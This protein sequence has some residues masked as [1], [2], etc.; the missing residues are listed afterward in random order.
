[1]DVSRTSVEIA[2]DLISLT[3]SLAPL[4]VTLG[5]HA[6]AV[7]DGHDRSAAADGIHS[8]AELLEQAAVRIEGLSRELR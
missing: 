3:R 2:H 7:H 6:G 8:C 4:M 5:V 1:V